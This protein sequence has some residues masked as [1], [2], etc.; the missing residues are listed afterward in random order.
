MERRVLDRNS[1]F[2]S[3][4]RRQFC[5]THLPLLGPTACTWDWNSTK[6]CMHYRGQSKIVI[7]Y[8]IQDFRNTTTCLL[9][10]S[11]WR[12][13]EVRR[14]QIRR[15]NNGSSTICGKGPH[16]LLWAIS[17]AAR[18]NVTVNYT[19]NHLKLLCKLYSI[20]TIYIYGRGFETHGLTFNRRENANCRT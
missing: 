2:C 11:Y 1:M 18:K 12:Y 10:H 16:S 20:Y 17:Q 8:Q 4:R 19:S 3:D 7:G 13:G 15:L 9:T 14:L 5:G 6:C